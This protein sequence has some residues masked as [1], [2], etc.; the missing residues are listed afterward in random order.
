MTTYT[1]I[2]SFMTLSQRFDPNHDT[3][4]TRLVWRRHVPWGLVVLAREYS[5]GPEVA[6]AAAASTE[7]GLRQ[8][9]FWRRG[10]AR[11]AQRAE[12]RKSVPFQP[13]C[14]GFLVH[15]RPAQHHISRVTQ[16]DGTGERGHA[17]RATA[18]CGSFG[19]REI[20]EPRRVR[21]ISGVFATYEGN[22]KLNTALTALKPQQLLSSPQITYSLSR[23]HPTARTW[24]P[25]TDGGRADRADKAKKTRTHVDKSARQWPPP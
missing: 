19:M 5:C 12:N 10:R 22:T 15:V 3:C 8:A 2:H 4:V 9:P 14:T 16:E 24:Q 13:F 20:V 18:C 17:G 6:A 7:N 21:D 1:Y 11:R 23:R 25:A